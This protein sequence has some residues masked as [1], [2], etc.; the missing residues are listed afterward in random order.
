MTSQASDQA[1]V[2]QPSHW[3]PLLRIG[4]LVLAAAALGIV[5]VSIPG[6]LS[7]TPMYNLRPDLIYQPSPLASVLQIMILVVSLLSALFSIGLATLLFLK[8]FNDRMGQYLAYYLLF[9]GVLFAGPIEFL[10]PYWPQAAWVNSFV[11]LPVFFGPAS[12]ALFAMFPDGH[13]VP[14][15]SRWLVL[16]SLTVLPAGLIFRRGDLLTA[17]TF[18]AQVLFLLAGIWGLGMLAMLLYV[19]LYRYRHVATLE[20]RQQTKWV[21]FGLALTFGIQIISGIPWIIALNLPVGS[22]LPAWSPLVSLLWILSTTFFPISLTVAV[23]RYRLYE[24]DP[25]I[26][27]ALVYGILSTALGLAYF[28]AIT[29]LQQALP[30]RSQPGVVILTLS[31]AVVF[32]PLR[33]RVQTFID[34]RFYRSKYNAEQ[35]LAAFSMAAREQVELEKLSKALLS[36]IDQTMQPSS[37]SL[38]LVEGEQVP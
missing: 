9:H 23:M 31:I 25:L 28:G 36:I 15:W 34:R 5:L 13:F 14:P 32:S 24:L 35:A 7:S 6:Y 10:Q 17:R 22:V 33:A 3:A 21:V 18:P 4:W 11:L 30:A 29:L 38:W 1:T 27:R 12:V 2:I 20:Q 8:K 19:P 26:N 37:C 16:A